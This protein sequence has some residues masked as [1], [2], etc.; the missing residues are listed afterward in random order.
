V[1]GVADRRPKA[2]VVVEVT[3]SMCF[4]VEEVRGDVPK[5]VSTGA[6]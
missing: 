5:G 3:C 1:C 6:V 4:L 2:D